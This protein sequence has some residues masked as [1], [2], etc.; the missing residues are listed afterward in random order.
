MVLGA[1][2]EHGRVAWIEAPNDI[3]SLF[4]ATADGPI[5]EIGLALSDTADFGYE[6]CS[7][8]YLEWLGDSVVAISHERAN[9][10]VWCVRFPG[11][12][13][14]RLSL[15]N[16]P[17]VD[18]D[19]LLWC[20]AEPQLL[21]AVAL[22]S[23]APRTPLPIRITA[24]H[25][26]LTVEPSG[27][28][29]VKE[30]PANEWIEAERLALPTAAQRDFPAAGDDFVDLV[31]GHLFG[32]DPAPPAARLFVEAVALPFRQASSATW[33]N[34]PVWL[35]V[36]W[37]RHLV[38]RGLS[39]EAHQ[40]LALLDAIAAPLPESEPERG[41]DPSWPFL[42]GA[43]NL[44]ARHVR[45]QARLQAGACRRGELPRGFYC[46][47]FEPAPGRSDYGSRVDP[48]LLPPALRRAF[49]ILAPTCPKPIP[50]RLW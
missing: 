47:F 14:G 30:R 40:F 10:Y 28:L 1:V 12:S 8:S 31:V 34:S 36:Y 42:E 48:G 27:Q 38:A 50:H 29:C 24:R 15:S 25:L 45:R 26:W 43:V 2:D 20:G 37:H 18:G 4:V 11:G 21:R 9:H 39:A 5:V 19:L 13:I 22:P 33:H 32:R 16:A 46:L 49:E 7:V 3:A 35:P 44:A 17:V 6:G 23:L 41:W